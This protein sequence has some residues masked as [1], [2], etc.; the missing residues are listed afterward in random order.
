MFRFANPEY[1]TLLLILPVLIAGFIALNIH[2][3]K[4]VEKLGELKLV[5]R[6]M[7][8]LSLKR[9]YLKFWLIFTAVLMGILVA[10]RPQFGTKVEVV[11]RQ[12]IELVVAIDVSNSM[13][14]QDVNPDR[15]S[16]AKQI[17]TRIIDERSNDKVAIVV[18]AGEAFVQLPMTSD[19][20]AAKIFLD[21]INTSLVPI[22]GTV[23]GSAINIAMNSFTSDREVDKSIILITDGETHDDNPVDM[24]KR[25]AEADIQINVVGIGSPEGSPVPVVPYSNDMKK[26]MQGNVVV[27]KLNEEMCKE[28]AEAGKGMYVRADNSNNALKS[29]QAEL[30]KLQKK[31]GDEKAYSDYDEKFRFFAWIM[32]IILFI[33]VCIFDKKNRLF[34]NVMLFDRTSKLK[35][36]N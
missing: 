7:P 14:A 20:Q 2:K 16:R 19:I 21:N 33:E 36:K 11:E 34:R 4:S 13:L 31:T 9:S 10:A 30:D 18:F 27:S 8:E 32:L 25:A 17:L 24:A 5:K 22:Q 15:L 1:L 3:K 28:I 12:G 29:L 26:D 6:L 35:T 23:I